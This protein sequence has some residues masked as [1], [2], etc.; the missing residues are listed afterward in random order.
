MG[1]NPLLFHQTQNFS[2]YFVPLALTINHYCHSMQ[3]ALKIAFSSILSVGNTVSNVC[4]FWIFV[5]KAF[6]RA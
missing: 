5:L 3:V 4:H 2:R 1:G 6:H